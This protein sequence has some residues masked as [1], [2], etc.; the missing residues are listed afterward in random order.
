MSRKK[1]PEKKLTS[2]NSPFDSN[3]QGK[4]IRFMNKACTFLMVCLFVT[5]GGGGRPVCVWGRGR[6]WLSGDNLGG[7]SP[8]CV[9]P[10]TRRLAEGE[11]PH[12]RSDVSA[13]I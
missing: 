6:G 10:D 7:P 8:I 12:Y 2:R 1:P 3:K 4:S 13:R 5:P 9:Y 11:H